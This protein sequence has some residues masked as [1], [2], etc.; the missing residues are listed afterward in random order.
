MSLIVAKFGGTS[1]KDAAAM[2]KSAEVAK[3]TK[4]QVV[5]V[6]ATSGTTNLFNKLIESADYGNTTISES[7]DS[8]FKELK[9]KHLEI[10]TQLLASGDIQGKVLFLID[11][12]RSSFMNLLM[13]DEK[14]RDAYKD[15]LYSYGERISSLLFTQAMN[16]VGLPSECVDARNFVKTNSDFLKATPN[17]EKMKKM[18]D[19]FVM[20]HLKAGRTIVT[21]GFIGSNEVGQTTTLGRGG[22]DYSAALI[23][24]AVG[25]ESLY[26]WTDVT[27]IFTLDPRINPNAKRIEEITYQEAAELASF[28]AKVLHPSSLMPAMRGGFPIF[29]G[30]SGESDA[31]GT[32][33]VSST[34]STP[35]IRAL[36]KRSNQKLLTL[37]SVKMVGTHGFLA[38]IFSILA[39][40]KVNVD[41]VTTS[42]TSVALTLD[43]NNNGCGGEFV[44]NQE[45]LKELSSFC[46]VEVEQNLSLIALI[47]NNMHFTPGLGTRAFSSLGEFNIRSVSHGASSHNLCFLVNTQD[48]DKILNL[49]HIDFIEAK[50]T[51][52]QEASQ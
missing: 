3:K 31:Q 49:L 6:S 45:M 22:S 44:F 50:N 2:L 5:V 8:I 1:V 20:P 37:N 17:I 9:E 39:K 43:G 16:N 38:N 28:G 40:F 25:A 52:T 27:G 7:I 36:A 48:E 10:A 35:F 46:H 4:A 13:A 11:E 24:E 30:S 18:A 26:I 12:A 51:R 34:K 32:W 14:Y 15:E 33:V 19:I 47:G 29:V 42:E 41:M 21:Q 23:A